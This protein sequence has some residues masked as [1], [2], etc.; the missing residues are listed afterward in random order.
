VSDPSEDPPSAAPQPGS[1][2]SAGRGGGTSSGLG[3]SVQWAIFKE[4]SFQ[5]G[6]VLLIFG[7][8]LAIPCSS[9]IRGIAGNVLAAGLVVVLFALFTWLVRWTQRESLGNPRIDQIAR[10]LGWKK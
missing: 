2:V 9:F 5:F 7:L 8:L 6:V 3:V 4:N 10:W 1:S